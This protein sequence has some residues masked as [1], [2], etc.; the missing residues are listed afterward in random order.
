MIAADSAIKE[1]EPGAGNYSLRSNLVC[2]CV[3][4]SALRIISTSFLQL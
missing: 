4:L 2:V 1:L 3:C